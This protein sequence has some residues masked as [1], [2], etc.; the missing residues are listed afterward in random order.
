MLGGSFNPAHEGHRHVAL[1]ALRRL[2]LDEIWWLVSPQ[3]PL[4]ATAGMSSQ[5]ARLD[6]ARRMAR[7]PAFRVT[8]LETR[9]GTRYTADTLRVLLRRFPVARFVWL[10]GA[11]NLAQIPQWERWPSIFQTVA[12]AVLDRSPYSLAALASKA[13]RRFAKGRRRADRALLGTGKPAWTYIRLH[14]H[15]AS[16]SAIRSRGN[17]VGR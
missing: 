9:L 15:P 3:N 7:H 8:G 17:S 13:A 16:A 2:G 5:A 6:G 11:D 1:V 12:V 14:C 10:M 4:K